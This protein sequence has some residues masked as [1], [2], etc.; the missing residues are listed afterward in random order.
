[1]HGYAVVDRAFIN[2]INHAWRCG[3]GSRIG[4]ALLLVSY[5][6]AV[7]D[8]IGSRVHPLD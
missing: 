4:F 7:M 8:L 1:M 3:R 2:L 6:A 5:G